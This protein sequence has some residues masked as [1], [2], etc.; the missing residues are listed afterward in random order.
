MLGIWYLGRSVE[1]YLCWHVAP[2]LGRTFAGAR[3]AAWLP[4][5]PA[6]SHAYSFARLLAHSLLAYLAVGW[7][8]GSLA[9]SPAAVGSLPLKVDDLMAH[10]IV[11][12]TS[13]PLV[14]SLWSVG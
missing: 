11:G 12:S 13:G 14:G 9:Y 1:L 6:R 3:F 2:L 4:R 7:H 10:N 8:I 5:L